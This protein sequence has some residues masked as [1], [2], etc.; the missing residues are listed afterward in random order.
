MNCEV[1]SVSFHYGICCGLVE[2]GELEVCYDCYTKLGLSTWYWKKVEA[3]NEIEEIIKAARKS[4][5]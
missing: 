5:K 4:L 3:E 2:H 1:C